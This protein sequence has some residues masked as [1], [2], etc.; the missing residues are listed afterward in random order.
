MVSFQKSKLQRCVDTVDFLSFCQF[1]TI[2]NEHSQKLEFPRGALRIYLFFNA[3]NFIMCFCT[4]ILPAT[5]QYKTSV[6]FLCPF[7]VWYIIYVMQSC[8]FSQY[9]AFLSRTV[10][11]RYKKYI[12]KSP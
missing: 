2:T 1:L 3:V 7:A 12:V 11:E 4:S 9:P 5:V 10:K 8:R 6:S